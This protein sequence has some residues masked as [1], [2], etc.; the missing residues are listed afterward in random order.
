[1]TTLSDTRQQIIQA[2]AGLI[3]RV[4]V[5]CH[6]PALAR[7]LEHVLKVTESN[8]WTDLVERIRKVLAGQRDAAL[9]AGL[10]DEDSTILEAILRGLQ[11][12]DTLPDPNAKPDPA[13]AA[14]GLANMIHAAKHNTQALQLLAG[15]SEQMSKAGGDMTRLAAV[16]R[17]LVNGERNPEKLATGMGAQGEQLLLSILSELAKLEQH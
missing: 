7:D 16:M 4:V 14:P 9:L 17:R 5:A 3:H 6:N 1:M 11:D 13:L 8:G 15:M 10:D 2:H 12:P